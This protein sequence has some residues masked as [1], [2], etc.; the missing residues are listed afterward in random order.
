MELILTAE[1]K[2]ALAMKHF[3]YINNVVEHELSGEIIG[4]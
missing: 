4:E 1:P 2:T 3:G